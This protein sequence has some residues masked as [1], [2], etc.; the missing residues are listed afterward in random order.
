MIPQ[1]SFYI[2]AD[3]STL[4]RST[5]ACRLAEK[6]WRHSVRTH[7]HLASEDDAK[8]MDALLWSFR[9]DSFLPHSTAQKENTQKENTQTEN[10]GQTEDNRLIPVT[11][12][13]REE[14][15]EEH[16]GLLINL[17]ESIPENT[18]QFSRVAEVVIQT[19]EVLQQARIRFKQ[20]REKGMAPQHQKVGAPS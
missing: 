8:N 1:V 7:I 9:E 15:F 16:Q 5:F 13:W 10:T 11:I 14:Q 6:A 4:A 19:D 2:L 18:G 3:E 17:S 12:G 20:Y